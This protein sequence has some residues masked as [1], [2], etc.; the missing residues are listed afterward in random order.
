[1][2]QFGKIT[3][4]V[5][6]NGYWQRCPIC[7]GHGTVPAGFYDGLAVGTGR[8]VCRRCAGTGTIETPVIA[9]M[10]EVVEAHRDATVRSHRP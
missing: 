3:V 8:Q 1:M 7:T 2:A 6:V 5:E 10:R 4:D 9:D